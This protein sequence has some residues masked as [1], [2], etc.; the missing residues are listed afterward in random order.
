MIQQTAAHLLK[1]NV[2]QQRSLSS[3]IRPHELQ[4]VL[5]SVKVLDG[6]WHMPNTNR[7]PYQEYLQKRIKGSQFFGIDTIKDTTTDLPHMLPSPQQ[8][9]D[10]VG[11]MGITEKDHVVVYDS[12]GVFSACRV[13]WT[14]KAF[15]HTSVS[16]LNGGLP[17]W[18]KEKYPIESGE[19][20]KVEEKEYKIPTL[21]KDIV[22]DYAYV[23]NNA[24]KVQNGDE[25]AAIVLDARPHSRFTGLAP[26]PREGLKS[27]HMPGSKNV[28]FNE[29]VVN[30]KMVDD[31]KLLKVFQSKKI[32]LNR[33]IITS[34]GKGD[35]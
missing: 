25:D 29:I 9:A 8:F 23:L 10:A 22:R 16:V 24:H 35:S 6:S 2:M 20:D 11:K 26:E 4:S 5:G 27:G 34:C 19:P 12:V 18:E 7:D 14:F 30:G 1:K 13:Y 3:L 17:L 32:D 33:D 28:S 21:N 15:N 31:D